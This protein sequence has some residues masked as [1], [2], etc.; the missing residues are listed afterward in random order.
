MVP[1]NTKNNRIKSSF[2]SA[3][4]FDLLLVLTWMR[5]TVVGYALIFVRRVPYI[6]VPIAEVYPLLVAALIVLALPWMLKRIRAT[7]ILLY[8]FAATVIL[9]TTLLYPQNAEHIYEELGNILTAVLPMI[10][11]GVCYDHER[12]KDWLFWASLLGTAVM[13]LYQVYQLSMDRELLEDSMHAAYLA[14]PGVMYLIYYAAEKKGVRYWVI[15]AAGAASIF[16]YGTRGPILCMAVLLA[17]YLLISI[18][19]MQSVWEKLLCVL[20][21]VA[22]LILVLSGDAMIHLAEWLSGI[23]RKIGFST[24]IFDFFLEGEMMNT[25]NRDI[26]LSRAIAGIWEEPLLG[27]GFFGDRAQ[28]GVYP[29]NLFVELWFQFGLFVGTALIAALIFLP[30]KA[31]RTQRGNRLHI[32]FLLMLLCLTYIKLMLSGSYAVEANFFF[33]IGVCLTMSRE[34]APLSSASLADK[35]ETL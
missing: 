20:G 9:L 29:H 21:I 11:L 34:T 18:R 28:F 6:G 22:A 4:A 27:Y 30:I 10:F 35:G 5:H 16:I 24:R 26:H 32:M 3:V 7:E 23:F 19:R 1:Q 33:M 8:L 25:T 31:L 15:A 14:L 17:V 13:F 2:S 12:H